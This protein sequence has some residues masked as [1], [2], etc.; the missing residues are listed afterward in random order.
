MWN[1]VLRCAVLCCAVL[2]CAVLCCAVLRC[3]IKAGPCLPFFTALDASG[4]A[5]DMLRRI[6]L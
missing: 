5:A 1:A 3:V 6:M 4:A 2:C